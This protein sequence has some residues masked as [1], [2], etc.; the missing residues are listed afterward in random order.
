MAFF[1]LPIQ[2]V[3]PG[4]LLF[5]NTLWPAACDN[6]DMATPGLCYGCKT[7][8]AIRNNRAP[9]GCKCCFAQRDIS[10]SRKP[11][12]TFIF[13]AMGWPS[14]FSDTAAT[15][16]TLLAEPRPLFPPRRSPPQ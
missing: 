2:C 9:L 7:R 8:Q 4:K 16:G 11:L 15:K 5:G 14:S 13:I 10:V 3:D 1:T 12:T 6:A